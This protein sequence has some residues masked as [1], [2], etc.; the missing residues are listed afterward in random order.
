MLKEII[1][2]SENPPLRILKVKVSIKMKKMFFF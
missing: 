1:E 2:N